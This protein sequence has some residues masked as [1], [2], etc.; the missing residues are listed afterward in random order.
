MFHVEQMKTRQQFFT[1]K[2]HL[3][4]THR[5]KVIWNNDKQRAE[6]E[7]PLGTDLSKY[8]KSNDYAS[9]KNKKKS[10]AELIYFFVQ[11]V[12]LRFKR[13]IIGLWRRYRKLCKVYVKEH[14]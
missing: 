5:F 10:L 12:M 9:H 7:I 1:A 14:I 8:Y 4:S 3:T 11:R 6:T 2:D 13:E